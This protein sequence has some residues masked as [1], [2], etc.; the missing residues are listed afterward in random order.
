MGVIS[1]TTDFGLTDEYVGVMKG[2]LISKAPS[3]RLV[4]LCHEIPPFDVAL[5]ADL[6][7]GAFRYFPSGTVH[8]MVVDP[9]VGSPRDI[10]CARCDGHFLLAPDNGLL[11]AIFGEVPPSGLC[12]VTRDDLRLPR[13]SATFHGRDIFAPV[14][15]YLHQTQDLS[16]LGP[17]LPFGALI[18]APRLELTASPGRIAVPVRRI[19]RFGNLITALSRPELQ[20][21]TQ[22]VALSAIT[23]E[24]GAARLRGIATC[25]A[26]AA[27]GAPLALFGSRDT[28]EIAISCGHA[29]QTLDIARGET[30]TL[31]W[32]VP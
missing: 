21:L 31:T 27:Q 28:L 5:A 1:L 6:V 23:I 7:K 22:G 24:V 26:D 29:A 17:A 8:L 25:Y 13:V 32:P 11:P 14:A 16:A 10:V 3:A 4:D 30:V 19:D 20:R 18:P 9:G 15:A 12:R 2:V